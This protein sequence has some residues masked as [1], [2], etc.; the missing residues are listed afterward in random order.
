MG[1]IVHKNGLYEKC[2]AH[3]QNGMHV[4]WHGGNLKLDNM[5]SID[6]NKNLTSQLSQYQTLKF[7]IKTL[8]IIKKEN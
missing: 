2:K 4:V 1:F 7:H 6:N 8:I 3:I 5:P